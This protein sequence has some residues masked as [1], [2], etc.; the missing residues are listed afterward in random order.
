MVEFGVHEC[1][2]QFVDKITKRK[3]DFFWNYKVLSHIPNYRD[4]CNFFILQVTSKIHG[5]QMIIK[6]NNDG[7]YYVMSQ[8]P[9]RVNPNNL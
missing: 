5:A 9:L 8:A 3:T 7:G 4:S 1:G 6:I 2:N